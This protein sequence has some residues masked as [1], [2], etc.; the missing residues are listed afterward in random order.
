MRI[1]SKQKDYFDSSGFIDPTL[2]YK[3]DEIK[4]DLEK[5][6]EFLKKFVFPSSD[7]KYNRKTERWEEEFGFVVGKFIAAQ[8]CLGRIRVHGFLE[9]KSKTFI[10]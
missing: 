5:E 1:I 10:I 7:I 6:K 8:E 3:R 2:I 4:I 9:K